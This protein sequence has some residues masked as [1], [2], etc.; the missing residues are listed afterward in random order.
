[1][2]TRTVLLSLAMAF[3]GALLF[4]IAGLCL[5]QD[6]NYIA[7]PP[8]VQVSADVIPNGLPLCKSASLVNIAC[9]SPPFIKKAY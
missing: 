9:Y 2:K 4:G 7:D 3:I 1:M 8:R 6:F 5:A